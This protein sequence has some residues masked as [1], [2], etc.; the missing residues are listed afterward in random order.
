MSFLVA[1]GVSVVFV[2]TAF[3]VAVAG[4]V[5]DGNDDA[6][7]VVVVVITVAVVS[8]YVDATGVAVALIVIVNVF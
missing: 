7:V 4:V 3:V 6:D 5:D 8:D 1:D 2:V